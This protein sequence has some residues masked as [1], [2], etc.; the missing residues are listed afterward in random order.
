MDGQKVFKAL[1][2][3]FINTWN[4]IDQLQRSESC[5]RMSEGWIW[6]GRIRARILLEGHKCVYIYK[7]LL[8][9]KKI[10]NREKVIKRVN[11]L[12]SYTTHLLNGFVSDYKQVVPKYGGLIPIQN[13]SNTGQTKGL[14]FDCY[15]YIC[16]HPKSTRCMSNQFNFEIILCSS[17]AGDL[18]FPFFSPQTKL[19]VDLQLGYCT[20]WSS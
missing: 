3:W 6:V 19:T 4:N 13:E 20:G 9:I 15:P 18:F 11:T 16:V 2:F 8:W 12:T 1:D 17:C 5:I 7:G 14:G 10:F